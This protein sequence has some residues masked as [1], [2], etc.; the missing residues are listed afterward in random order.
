MKINKITL[1]EWLNSFDENRIEIYNCVSKKPINIIY[2]PNSSGKSLIFNALEHLFSFNRKPFIKKETNDSLWIIIEFTLN[3]KKYEFISTV[4][5]PYNITCDWEEVDNFDK[6]L[7]SNIWLNNWKLKYYWKDKNTLYWVNRFSFLDSHWI[8]DKEYKNEISFIDTGFDWDSR[9]IILSYILWNEIDNNKFELITEYEHI[10]NFIDKNKK[11]Q[12]YEN[13]E[14]T[15]NLISSDIHNLYQELSD[16]RATY[17]DVLMASKQLQKLKDDYLSTIWKKDED[18]IFIENEL[19]NLRLISKD[20]LNKIDENKNDIKDREL[21]EKKDLFESKTIKNK[22]IERY[23]HYLKYKKRLSVMNTFALDSYI[24]SNIEPTIKDFKIF[25]WKFY[26]IFIQN[27]IKCWVIKKDDLTNMENSII[28]DESKL[29]IKAFF[30]TSEWIRKTIRVLTF[31]WLHIYWNINDNRCLNISF[32]DS[33]IE[34]I[35][36]SLRK[37]LFHSLFDF[38]KKENFT[39]PEMFLFI[40]KVENDDKKTSINEIVNDFDKYICLIDVEGL[41]N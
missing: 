13:I 38:I 15:S 39:T 11:L 7:S 3:W 23:N 16:L 41:R 17:W 2:M 36:Y 9:K 29:K 26:D 33:F 18:Y 5:T 20:T 14:N 31:M 30:K 1:I 22:D 4:N 25:I 6:I 27:C 12:K 28:F 8:N 24:S 21:I 32:Y 35:D 37:V 40:T 19:N 34:N 10:K